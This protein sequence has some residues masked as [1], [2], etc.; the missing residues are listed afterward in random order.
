M[1]SSPQVKLERTRSLRHPRSVKSSISHDGILITVRPPRFVSFYFYTRYHN[2]I[3]THTEG[4][5]LFRLTSPTT[6]NHLFCFGTHLPAPIY[7]NSF[8][9][10]KKFGLLDALPNFKQHLQRGYLK[11][12]LIF[13]AEGISLYISLLSMCTKN[14]FSNNGGFYKTVNFLYAYNLERSGQLQA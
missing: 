7:I 2:N 10:I 4:K 6:S 14:R 11:I 8:I 1:L 13:L 3:R 9:D 12:S 5:N